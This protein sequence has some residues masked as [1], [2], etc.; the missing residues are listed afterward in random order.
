MTS[1]YK[2]STAGRAMARM[3]DLARRFLVDR[4]GNFAILTCLIAPIAIGGAGVAVDLT[5]ASLAKNQTQSAADAAAIAGAAS[6]ADGTQT[7]LTVKQY[8]LDFV[9][10]SMKQNTYSTDTYTPTVT[11][12]PSVDP[13][14]LSVL[15]T[16]DVQ[17]QQ[18]HTTTPLTSMMGFKTLTIAVDATAK[19]SVGQQNSLSMYFV[20]DRSGSMQASTTQ[21]NPNKSICMYEKY[22]LTPVETLTPTGNTTCYYYRIQVLQNSVQALLDTFEAAD[23]QHRLIR[24]GADSYNAAADPVQNTGWGTSGVSSYVSKLVAIDGTSSTKAFSNAVA[25]LT[26]PMENTYHKNMNG[27]VP[28]KYIVYM[29][30]GA[31][32]NLID[33]TNTLAQCTAAKLAGITVYTVGFSAPARGKTLLLA[34][35]SAPVDFYDASDA[36]DL[37]AAFADIAKETSGGL[38]LLTN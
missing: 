14:T 30:D 28:K 16:V 7:I 34:C 8:V 20:L 29:T 4:T 3:K 22:T 36:D 13:A 38:P 25:A 26:D 37:N 10:G 12:T 32:N 24:T 19:S 2:T 21:R 15:Y 18:V 9:S 17:L 1:D 23:P 11:I 33:D 31:N 5:S 27:L 6:L 35:A